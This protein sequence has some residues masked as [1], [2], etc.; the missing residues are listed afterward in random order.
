MAE[1]DIPWSNLG[2]AEDGAVFKGATQNARVLSE[3]WIGANAFC[4][5]CGAEPLTAFAANAPVADFHCGVCAEEYELKATKGHIDRKLV[6]GVYCAMTARLAEVQRARDV[7]ANLRASRC[8]RGAPPCPS[9]AAPS[10]TA[11]DA[12]PVYHFPLQ[13]EGRDGGGGDGATA[14]QG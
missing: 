8:E 9:F 13:Q 4:S 1:D 10:P 2:F 7:S 3:G 6:N 11:S 5:N 14:L 12:P